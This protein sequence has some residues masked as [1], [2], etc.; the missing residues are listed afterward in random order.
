MFRAE[1][2]GSG[3]DGTVCWNPTA[4]WPTWC[5]REVVTGQGRHA[6]WFCWG[7][8]LHC[9]SQ[10]SQVRQSQ[11][12]TGEE[13]HPAAWGPTR[14]APLGKSGQDSP[15]PLLSFQVTSASLEASTAAHGPP[16]E[17]EPRPGATAENT[18][19]G[20]RTAQ[21]PGPTRC[22]QSGV[23]G[24][25]ADLA[26]TGRHW[27]VPVSGCWRGSCH[28]QQGGWLSA[29]SLGA[30]LHP[31]VTTFSGRAWRPRLPSLSLDLFFTLIRD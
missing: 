27:R 19:R 11:A 24:A 29:L 17:P 3:S 6:P 21:D 30:D 10:L 12:M 14:W 20:P 18:P 4:Q 2:R 9:P 7:P 28:P 8:A 25:G 16:R 5:P 1:L 31:T 22:Q 13:W 23:A 15:C 26:G